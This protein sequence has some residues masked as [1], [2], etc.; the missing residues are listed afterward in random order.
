MAKERKPESTNIEKH[1]PYTQKLAA[2]QDIL[3]AIQNHHII[4]A[5]ELP[6]RAEKR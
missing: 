2:I 5:S 4:D 3:Q 1:I 6:S